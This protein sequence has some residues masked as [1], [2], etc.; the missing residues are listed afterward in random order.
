M[1]SRL[2]VSQSK[3]EGLRDDL[4]AG[5]VD[6]FFIKYLLAKAASCKDFGLLVVDI[7]AAFMHAGTDEEIYVKVP[8]G[9]KSSRFWRLTAAV[10]GTR[11]ASK[12]WQE[13]SCDKL[14]TRTLF[15]Q[16][17]IISCIFKRFCDNLDLEQHAGDFLVCG[18]TSNLE[19]LADEFKNHFLVKK[20]E[21][22][23]LRGL[24]IRK[25]PIFS[26]FE[27]LWMILGGTLC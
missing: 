24:S 10:S 2:C 21:I 8:S 3:A 6:T 5:T 18:L 19:L 13:L 20:A 17:D 1:R 4:F 22:V 26:N 14:V 7:S 15:Q 11:K 23:S 9:I 27:F 16:N 12:H 25:K